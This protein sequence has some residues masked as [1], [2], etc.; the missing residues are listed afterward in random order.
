MNVIKHL[1]SD[2]KKKDGKERTFMALGAIFLLAAVT[3]VFIPVLP[4]VP[5][6]VIAAYLFSKGSPRIH[7]WIRD[8]RYFGKPVRDWED[9]RVIRTRTKIFSTAAMTVGGAIAF[10][11]FESPWTYIVPSLFVAAIVFVLTRKSKP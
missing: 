9:H 4:Q 6:A 1:A 3:G 11:K 5:F 8:N 10:F 2:W 7:K